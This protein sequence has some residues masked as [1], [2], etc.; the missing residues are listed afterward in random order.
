MS[1]NLKVILK[2]SA[3][4]VAPNIILIERA[5]PDVERILSNFKS[6]PTGDRYSVI[7]TDPWGKIGYTS[8]L[9]RTPYSEHF[10]KEEDDTFFHDLLFL[11]D[12]INAA[13]EVY[14]EVY[15]LKYPEDSYIDNYGLRHYR[16]DFSD[17]A[18]LHTD[19]GGDGSREYL[20]TLNV[21]LNSG[22]G[23][24]SINFYEDFDESTKFYSHSPNPG[25]IV[26]FPSTYVHAVEK[27][28]GCDRYNINTLLV[29]DNLAK[30]NS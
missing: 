29:R 16:H 15:D 13:Y 19:S 12:Y 5:I 11:S 17:S 9:R 28:T 7:S 10:I 24:G 27:I 18:G 21:Y 14:S 30:N 4:E 6:C 26:L 25:D 20:I 2:E 3:K 1:E 23:G 8:S 22:F